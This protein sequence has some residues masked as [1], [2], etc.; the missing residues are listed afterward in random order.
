MVSMDSMGFIMTVRGVGLVGEIINQRYEFY[1]TSLR[2][3]WSKTLLRDKTTERV[4]SI[5]FY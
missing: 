3:S 5:L 2:S 4:K 1:S